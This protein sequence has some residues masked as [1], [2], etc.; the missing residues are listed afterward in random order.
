[1]VDPAAYK[2][3]SGYKNRLWLTIKLKDCLTA[4]SDSYPKDVQFHQLAMPGMIFSE[5]EWFTM[6]AISLMNRYCC[7]LFLWLFLFASFCWLSTYIAPNSS[8]MFDSSSSTRRSTTWPRAGSWMIA[9]SLQTLNHGEFIH[10]WCTP[11][12]GYPIHGDHSGVVG[13][14]MDPSEFQLTVVGDWPW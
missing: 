13:A 11:L 7:H 1:M 2:S 12:A 5:Y 3:P 14:F 8:T 9:L 6:V 4:G 10:K